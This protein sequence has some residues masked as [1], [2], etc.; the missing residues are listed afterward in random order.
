MILL[1]FSLTYLPSHQIY[2]CWAILISTWTMS[3][4][5]HFLLSFTLKLTLSFSKISRLI[6]FPNIKNINLAPLTS[7]I[8]SFC[9]PDTHNLSTPDALVSHYNT[10][11]HKNLNSLA[12]L[13]NRSVS[14]SVSAP[15][16][17]PDFRLMKAKGWQL[18]H[19]Y[20][21]T[22]LTIHKEMYNNHLVCYKDSILT[23][24]LNTTLV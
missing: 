22:G 9:F 4:C 13:K 21:K 1:L 15:W 5:H 7:S 17:T 14:F 3:I 20:R 24:K 2:Y 23:P 16:F 12:P 6:S 19:L 10:G 8:H 11:L 18:E